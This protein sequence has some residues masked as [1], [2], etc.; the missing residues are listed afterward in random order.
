M[1]SQFTRHPRVLTGV[2]RSIN[3]SACLQHSVRCLS[4]KSD[5]RKTVLYDFHVAHGG[6]MVPFAGWMMPVQYKDMG[7]TQSHLHTRSHAS[8]FDVSHMLQTNVFGKDRVS[9][10]ESL[11]VGDVAGLKENQGTLSLFTREDG[12]IMDDLIV[13][14]T[15]QDHLYVVSNAGCIEQDLGHMQDRAETMR[16]NG[17]DVTLEVMSY[18]LL[19]LQGPSMVA[20]LQPAVNIDLTKLF[21]MNSVVTSVFGVEGCRVTRCGYT[22][23]DGV[24]ISI[25]EDKTQFVLESLLECDDIRMAGLGARD[26]LRLEAGLCLYG[27]DI[28]LSTSPIEATLAWTIPKRR[29]AE[30]NFPGASIILQQL[31]DKPKRKR[32]G[33]LSTGAP[34]RA[35][36]AIFDASGEE[37]I[38]QITSGCPSPSLKVN[39][40]MGYIQTKYAKLG[41]DVKLQVRKKMIDASISKMPF[42]PAKYHMDK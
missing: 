21:F 6:K 38:G 20:A 3:P 33:F 24:E 42:V 39:V 18:G 40:A 23:E 34:A 37:E 13:T 5:D 9:F 14:K 27:N 29:R 10:M 17:D 2:V 11:V 31:K 4:T 1:L 28:D 41:T 12:G 22:G 36:T 25:P 16:S 32:V 8:I 19:A 26:S 15:H 7:I 30:A 35:G